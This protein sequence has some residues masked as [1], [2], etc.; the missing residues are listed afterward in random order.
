MEPHR[1][2]SGRRA[3]LPA[4]LE[5]CQAVGLTEEDYWYFIE[6]AEQYNGERSEAYAHVPDIKNDVTT[7][8]V[9]FAVS[10]VLSG[11]AYLLAPKPQS[12]ELEE[13]PRSLKLGGGRGQDRFSQTEGF[14]AV[15]ELA[16]AG[17]T[18][19]LVFA[20]KVG[21]LGG[22]RVN[23]SLVWSQ[24]IAEKGFQQLRAVFAFSDGVTEGVPDY[25][26]LAIGDTLLEGYT[27]KKVAAYWRQ[28]GGRLLEPTNRITGSDAPNLPYSDAFSTYFDAGG[29]NFTGGV[30]PYFSGATFTSTQSKFGAYAPMFANT[31]YSPTPELIL[32]P[33]DADE[34]FAEDLRT[35]VELNKTKFSQGSFFRSVINTAGTEIVGHEGLVVEGDKILYR[36][37]TYVE[38]QN[39]PEFKPHQLGFVNSATVSARINADAQ[40]SEGELYLVG[41]KTLAVCANIEGSAGANEPWAP[42]K[43]SKDIAGQNTNG[44]TATFTITEP[45][46]VQTI[47]PVDGGAVGASEANAVLNPKETPFAYPLQRASVATVSNTRPCTATEL[48]IKSNVYRQIS[49]FTDVTAWPSETLIH[50]YQKNNGSIQLGTLNKY[51]RR[52]SFF[53][54]EVRPA[55][56]TDWIDVTG[57]KYFFVEGST[58]VDQ[59]HYIRIDTGAKGNVETEF[60]L[61]PVSGVGALATATA[62]GG[63]MR[64]LQYGFQAP[65]YYVGGYVIVFNGREVVLNEEYATNPEFIRASSKETINV[66]GALENVHLEPSQAGVFPPTEP[67]AEWQ[68]LESRYSRV[69]GNNNY[70]SKKINATDISA[71]YYEFVWDNIVRNAGRLP[72][73]SVEPPQRV[74]DQIVPGYAYDWFLR[75]PGRENETVVRYPETFVFRSIRIFKWV[76]VPAAPNEGLAAARVVP[77]RNERVE[78]PDASGLAFYV[79]QY[80]HVDSNGVTQ[81][82]YKW[83][84]DPNNRG[85]G[86]N[87]GDFVIVQWQAEEGGELVDIHG[88]TITGTTSISVTEF[89]RDAFNY[90]R[91]DAIQDVSAFEGVTS[92]NQNGPEHEV[93]ALNEKLA[94]YPP[95]YD[96]M[97]IGGLR[98]NSS[99]EWTSFNSFSAYMQK[100]IVLENLIDGSAAASNLL[101]DIVFG[102]MTNTD[103]GAGKIL[104]P[105]QVDKDS[106]KIAS[107]FCNANDFTWDGVV[108]DRIN[109][110]DWVFQNAQYALL[111]ATVVGGRFALIPAVPYTTTFG[112]GNSLKPDIKALF[113]DGN[114]RDMKVQW[115]GPKER[116]LFQAEMLWRE[117]T[118]NG[119]AKTR[120]FTMRLAD[121]E[122][123]SDK[124]PVETFDMSGF[125]TSQLHAARYAFYALRLRQQV[126][127]SITFQTTPQAAMGLV[128]GDYFKVASNSTHTS[129]FNNGSINDE[130]YVTSVE[131]L[132]NGSHSVYFWNVGTQAVREGTINVVSGRV[133][134][135]TFFN[136]VFTVV[137]TS[138]QQR[139]YKLEAL[140]YGEEGLIEITGSHM[141]LTNIG[142]L[143]IL[144]WNPADFVGL[145][146][147]LD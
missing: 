73:H 30:E 54:L 88:V 103:W 38:D 16:T 144:D 22:I 42:S 58:P 20:K 34:D 28:N 97:T 10:L 14:S 130:G 142:S 70:V 37:T 62:G 95:Q 125:C 48:I 3:L 91:F 57:T 86:Y 31:C 90:S 84:V 68:E 146:I 136:T 24:M 11:A 26:G 78:N 2:P 118:L 59:Y 139:V 112:I 111:D 81:V 69:P 121:S 13:R 29:A 129:R 120:Q 47:D 1:R 106:M 82:G 99:R 23:G 128:A 72:H 108:S 15:Q 147:I 50:K 100:G 143:K 21:S 93:V 55:G 79:R 80:I 52:L 137:T 12:P 36:L 114:M 138:E 6:L 124:D 45:G 39:S 43:Y 104:G 41:D 141:P 33:E 25:A 9:S 46:F 4:E 49:G 40:I 89:D 123:G 53:M 107:Q 132:A 67:T 76:E 87:S 32:I 115:L 74:E 60:R 109:F 134:D 131:D 44:K 133:A 17:Q 35:K 83:S 135:S 71:N 119:F 65:P 56:T 122:G 102:M 27:A 63:I 19:P 145:G 77:V 140:T 113:T 18:I 92:S 110:R 96:D 105:Q 116:Q 75:D 7:V 85:T 126:D 64:K 127:H 51:V 94:Q 117:E 8:L 66:E 101:P 61:R 5:L 98:I